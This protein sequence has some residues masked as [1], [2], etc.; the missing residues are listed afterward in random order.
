MPPAL[1]RRRSKTNLSTANDELDTSYKTDRYSN[2]FDLSNV[3]PNGNLHPPLRATPSQIYEGVKNGTMKRCAL[4]ML[5]MSEVREMRDFERAWEE[6]EL[7]GETVAM[8]TDEE[9]FCLIDT[10]DRSSREA[11]VGIGESKR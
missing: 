7:G 11:D 2:L 6:A 1:F 3:D 4:S 8:V 10:S 9:D 5:E